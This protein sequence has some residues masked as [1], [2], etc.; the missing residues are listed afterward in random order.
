[1]LMRWSRRPWYGP[2]VL[3]SRGYGATMNQ[4]GAPYQPFGS[5]RRSTD[6]A[7]VG[8]SRCLEVAIRT[9]AR[10]VDDATR[11]RT[12]T[13]YQRVTGQSTPTL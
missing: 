8:P 1:M 13:A 3:A 9:G 5:V 12:S 11:G 4:L 7:P 10:V 6:M 2:R